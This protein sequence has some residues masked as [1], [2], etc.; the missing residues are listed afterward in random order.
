MSKYANE[1]ICPYC[2]VTKMRVIHE[3][4]TRISYRCDKCEIEV[5]KPKDEKTN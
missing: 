5:H 3:T 2:K 4:K 1:M